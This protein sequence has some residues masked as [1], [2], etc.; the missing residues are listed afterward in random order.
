VESTFQAAPRAVA[1]ARHPAHGRERRAF[2]TA[3]SIA[4]TGL[5]G[6]VSRRRPA[7]V[8]RIRQTSATSLTAGSAHSARLVRA[9]INFCSVLLP[10]ARGAA[11]FPPCARAALCRSRFRPVARVSR[12]RSH[13]GGTPTR[14]HFPSGNSPAPNRSKRFNLILVPSGSAGST[15]ELWRSGAGWPLNATYPGVCHAEPREV[16]GICGGM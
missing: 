14:G 5:P 6:Q 13:D 2:R 10:V 12:I 3:P 11:S 1:D 15:M 16:Q 4:P 7:A 9:V 8:A